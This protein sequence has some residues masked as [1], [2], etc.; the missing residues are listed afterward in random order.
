MATIIT[1]HGTFAKPTETDLEGGSSPDLQ[2]WEA[3]STFEHDLRE[4]V[5]AR[6]GRLDVVPFVWPGDNSEVERRGAI[7][8]LKRQHFKTGL[9]AL[10]GVAAFVRQAGHHLADRSQAF[11]LQRLVLRFVE[12]GHVVAN[13]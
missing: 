6:D 7:F 13:G 5:E 10:Q 11:R 12:F 2:W 3:Q 9:A 1:V 8:D 4:L